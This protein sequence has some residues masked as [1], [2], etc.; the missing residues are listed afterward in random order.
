VPRKLKYLHPFSDLV[1]AAHKSRPIFPTAQP[2]R[3]SQ[4]KLLETLSFDPGPAK[5]REVRVEKRWKRDGIDGEL[6]SWSVGYGPRTQAFVLRPSGA[7][8]PLPGVVALHDHG[9]FK[10]YGKE[11]IADGPDKTPAILRKFRDDAYGGLAYANEL[12]RRGFNVLVHDTFMWGSRNFP[13]ETIPEGMRGL[14]TARVDQDANKSLSKFDKAIIIY[15][16][17]CGLHE[18]LLQRYSNLLGITLAG[19]VSFEDRVAANYLLSRRDVKRG[20][21]GCVGLSGGGMRSMLLQATCNDIGAAVVV[22]MMSTYQELLDLVFTH[23]YLMFPTEW[24]HYGD[25]CDIPAIRAP[26]PLMVQYD[27]QDPLFTLKG[28]KDAD[29]ELKKQYASVGKPK[30]YIGKFYPGKHKFDAPMQ[31]DAFDWMEDQLKKRER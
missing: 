10:Y 14:V 15:N 4:K 28:M 21:I 26:S 11:K 7:N 2:G 24:S 6:L 3:A 20:K 30:N 27:L 31:Q 9:G 18:H 12:A 22:G 13:F 19:V 5:P 23:T 1:T 17:S 8:G 16:L 25:F 29:R